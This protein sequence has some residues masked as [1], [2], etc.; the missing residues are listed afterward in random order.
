MHLS[1]IEAVLSHLK[2]YL[3]Y[4]FH[5]FG[6]CQRKCANFHTFFLNPSLFLIIDYDFGG[7][8]FHL[9]QFH[10]CKFQLIN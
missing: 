1:L 7:L 8:V 9:F 6:F 2:H 5:I 3:S 4:L 10:I